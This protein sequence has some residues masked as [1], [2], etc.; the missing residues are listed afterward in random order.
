AA[1]GDPA[2]TLFTST[3]AT[4]LSHAAWYSTLDDAQ[5]YSLLGGTSEANYQ[6]IA[7]LLDRDLTRALAA[8]DRVMRGVGRLFEASSATG[9]RSI[10]AGS[11]ERA[12]QLHPPSRPAKKA[13]QV[14][15]EISERI[16]GGSWP[17]GASLGGERELMA[18]FG[19]G[20]S[21][22]R[23]AIRSLERLGAVSMGRGG[24]CGLKVTAP[25][26]G[27]VVEASWR[28]LQREGAASACTDDARSVLH[29]IAARRSLQDADRSPA[30][31]SVVVELFSAILSTGAAH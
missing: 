13:E 24:A 15:R 18:R 9:A 28:Y 27:R 30:D 4:M 20:R 10:R 2:L 6:V 31:G 5:F 23:E 25:D 17:E 19:V 26:P 1:I 14:A 12:Y 3:L 22:I 29:G 7:A 16:R 11:T 8:D 21:V